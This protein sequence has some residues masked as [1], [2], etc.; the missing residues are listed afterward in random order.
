LDKAQTEA[1]ELSHSDYSRDN[2]KWRESAALVTAHVKP[3]FFYD[4]AGHATIESD[5][6]FKKREYV[7]G[8]KLALVYRDWTDQS[9]LT[10]LNLLDY[11]F[12]AARWLTHEDSEFQPSGR[13]FPALI[14][15]ID[16][17]DPSADNDR[18]KID[19]STK[20]YPRTRLEVAFKTP[21]YRLNA[22]RYWFSADF[23]YYQEID[24]SPAI[25]SAHLDHQIYFVAK[26][27]L[28][29]KFDVS[30]SN[31]K[32]PL[33]QKSDQVFALGWNLNF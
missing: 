29:Y 14:G 10:W 21:A 25:Q 24:A 32:L 6:Q 15:G 5:Q 13:S 28:P 19:P 7:Y 4:L 3:Q 33:D 11:P 18:L 16:G 12:A 17:V 22:T 26:L 2:P 30:Y 31:G 23:R 27:D 20:I 8:A 9:A 1:G